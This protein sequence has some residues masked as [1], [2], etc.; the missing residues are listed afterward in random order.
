MDLKGKVVL[1]TGGAGAIG[2]AYTDELLK[3]GAKVRFF[4][5]FTLTLAL[6]Y[7]LL[8]LN[9]INPISTVVSPVH[10]IQLSLPLVTILTITVNKSV[11]SH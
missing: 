9:V 11:E 4:A 10:M 8:L 1:I 3:N 5:L 7:C 6:H 2:R